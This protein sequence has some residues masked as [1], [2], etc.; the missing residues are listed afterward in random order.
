MLDILTIV[1]SS[2]WFANW[3]LSYGLDFFLSLEAKQVLVK[4]IFWCCWELKCA[5]MHTVWLSFGLGWAGLGWAMP[6]AVHCASKIVLILRDYTFKSQQ[7][8]RLNSLH[9]DTHAQRWVCLL[10]N[11]QSHE[12]KSKTKKSLLCLQCKMHAS[13]RPYWM[14]VLILNRISAECKMLSMF[15]CCVRVEHMI[16]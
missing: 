11:R 16:G 6:L 3:L 4:L 9:C 2:S 1:A 15:A 12:N 13:I 7:S 10:S 8:N 14:N 5:N